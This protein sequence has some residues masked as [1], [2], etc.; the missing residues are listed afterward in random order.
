VTVQDIVAA[1]RYM[2]IATADEHGVPWAT[3]VWFATEDHR[4]FFWVS[5]PNARHS[6]NITVR[7]DIAIA[8]FDSSVTPDDAA[9][10]YMPARAEQISPGDIGVF[11][12]ESARQGLSVWGEAD[13]TAPAKHR[14]Y[15]ATASE[16]FTLGPGD[17][18]VPQSV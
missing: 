9:A 2:V 5:D 13:V 14:L 3:P 6:R 17:E 8:I 16:H 10:V 18:R 11:A 15:R 12:R 4:H 1:N 7:R